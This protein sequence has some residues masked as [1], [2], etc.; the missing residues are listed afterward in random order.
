L[1]HVNTSLLYYD[2]YFE[3]GGEHAIMPAGA[4]FCHDVL[5]GIVPPGGMK[6]SCPVPVDGGRLEWHERV[7]VPGVRYHSD[8]RQV[9]SRTSLMEIT[10]RTP[11]GHQW[12]FGALDGGALPLTC[13]M[14]AMTGAVRVG[15]G[16]LATELAPGQYT[17]CDATRPILVDRPDVCRFILVFVRRELVLDDALGPMLG[18]PMPVENMCSLLLSH[19]EATVRLGSRLAPGALAAAADVTGDLMVATLAGLCADADTSDVTLRA[20]IDAFIEMRLRDPDLTVRQ[21]AV[22]HHVSLRTVHR[23]FEG[24]DEGVAECIRGRRLDRCRQEILTRQD[25]SLSAI[26]ARWGIG[27]PKHFAR[28]YRTRFGESPNSTRQRAGMAG[29]GPTSRQPCPA[30]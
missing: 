6:Y 4:A 5:E 12:R 19:V 1:Q 8:R 24:A 14:A 30:I 23:L 29:I 15:Q 22:A 3:S 16:T 2:Q 27:D 11:S 21:I 9:T 20:R 7:G 10:S 13:L 18:R 28:K 26:C 17:V 25:L